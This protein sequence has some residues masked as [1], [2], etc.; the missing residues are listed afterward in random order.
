[1]KSWELLEQLGLATYVRRG[2]FQM[3]AAPKGYSH[4]LQ[5]GNA[6]TEMAMSN[7]LEYKRVKALHGERAV[8]EALLDDIRSDVVFWDVGANVGIYSCLVADVAPAGTVI[9]FEP[10]P[11]N[12]DRL[13][14]NLASNDPA[15]SWEV[16][17]VA[18][19]ERDG[20]ARLAAGFPADYRAVGAG[21]YYLS[22]TDGRPIDVRR[23]ESLIADGFP[24]PDVVKIDVQGAELDVL[25]G[26]GDEL[27]SVSTAY[28]EL[29]TGKAKRY[30]TTVRETEAFLRNAGF[31]LT[32]LGE[33]SG[34]REGVYHV[35]ASR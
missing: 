11:D 1:M 4:G 15:C 14:A 7:W 28:V 13:R 18:L 31:S 34:F 5:V 12:R 23:A 10:E 3:R 27:D 17:A 22:A 30:D 25:R 20:S 26:F 29:H 35:R 24:A 16:S 9:A 2:Y 32:Q 8:V 33:P 6:S 21:H 19:S